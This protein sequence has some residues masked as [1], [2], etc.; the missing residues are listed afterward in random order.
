M[1]GLMEKT[2]LPENFNIT[3]YLKSFRQLAPIPGITPNTNDE[4]LTFMANSTFYNECKA[5]EKSGMVK[6]NG[7]TWIILRRARPLLVKLNI[8]P[9][10]IYSGAKVFFVEAFDKS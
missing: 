6:H 5:L 10:A 8:I 1:S 4:T 3:E 7:S 2:Q 9:I